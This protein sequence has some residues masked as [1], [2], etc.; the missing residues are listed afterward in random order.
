MVALLA[1]GK[2]S[3]EIA[4]ALAISPGT[5][6]SHRRSICRKLVAHSTAELIHG[7]LLYELIAFELPEF[8]VAARYYALEGIA[9]VAPLPP[10]WRGVRAAKRSQPPWVSAQAPWEV[11]EGAFAASYWPTP[12]R[13]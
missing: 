3:K 2:T 7:A 13:N 8:C 1:R 4:A 9:T 6:G 10:S 5:A 11:T 12:P